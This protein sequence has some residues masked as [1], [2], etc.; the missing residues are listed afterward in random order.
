M[1][2]RRTRYLGWGFFL[3]AAA[4][5]VWTW[6]RVQEIARRGIPGL[7]DW[8]QVLAVAGRF[9]RD[10]AIPPEAERFY[11]ALV[12]R[13]IGE[14]AAA[15][16]ASPPPMPLTIRLLNP[17][18][19]LEANVVTFRAVLQ[20]LEELYRRLSSPRSPMTVFFGRPL[21]HLL[22]QQ[23]GLL[24]GYLS[25]RVLGQYDIALL[26]PQSPSNGLLYFVEP[27]IRDTQAQLGLS[28]PDFSL[29]V[30]LHETTHAFEFELHPWL[31]GHLNGLLKAYLAE[32]ENEVDQ[33]SRSLSPS[34]LAE[35]LEHIRRGESWLLW[36]LT[37]RQRALFDQMQALMSIVEG[38][39]NYVMK[40]VGRRILPTFD[41]IESRL[42]ARQAQRTAAE[43]LF[44]RLSGLELKLEQYR[45]G[46]SFAENV[47]RER[48]MAFLQRVWERPENLPTLAELAHPQVWIARMEEADVPASR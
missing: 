20:P 35:L 41:L 47:A 27:N 45:L 17:R 3:G 43:R 23:I 26:G 2:D 12:S 18:E 8:E 15:T 28:G 34:G 1:A 48:G 29:W 40:R 42:A 24:L 36:T 46:E 4:G 22:S 10:I 21:Q 33:V 38:Y 39:S 30:A 6:W 25:Q 44:L 31:R 19:W 7:V 14:V 32:V 9:G 13:S 5:L 37:P 16:E 11:T